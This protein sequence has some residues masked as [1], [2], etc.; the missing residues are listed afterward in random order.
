VPWYKL[1]KLHADLYGE[2]PKAT[3]PLSALLETW[4]RNRVRRVNSDDYGGPKDGPGRADHFVGAHGVSF[5]T[6]V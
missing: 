5:L 1:P 6:V 4:H 3:L 2:D